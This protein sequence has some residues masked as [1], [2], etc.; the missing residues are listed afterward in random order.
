MARRKLPIAS[1]HRPCRQNAW[2]RA[3]WESAEY[4]FISKAHGKQACPDAS[5]SNSA[6]MAVSTPCQSPGRGCRN[7]RIVG[8]QGLSSRSSSQR[9]SGVK[10]SAVQTGTPRAPAR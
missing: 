3:E 2:P 1:S 8:Y 5:F 10:G 4:G 6:A 7:K 9:Q